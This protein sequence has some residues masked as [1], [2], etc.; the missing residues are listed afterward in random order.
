M[1]KIVALSTRPTVMLEDA[2]QQQQQS[3]IV[4]LRAVL[5]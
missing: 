1:T 5:A 4:V 2:G 3:I